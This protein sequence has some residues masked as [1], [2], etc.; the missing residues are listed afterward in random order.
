MS[1][2]VDR[3]LH[4]CYPRYTQDEMDSKDAEIDRLKKET[5]T[6]WRLMGSKDA[7]IDRLK[8]LAESW[9]GAHSVAA[10]DR[11]LAKAEIDRLKALVVEHSSNAAELA[12]FK[13]DAT[14]LIGELAD[15]L[16]HYALLS[17]SEKAL[18]TRAREVK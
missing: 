5:D 2:S 8:E 9:K 15:A 6:S 10:M 13:K 14:K 4:F 12:W 3:H 1:E 17:P 11:D 7:E 18:I 16:S